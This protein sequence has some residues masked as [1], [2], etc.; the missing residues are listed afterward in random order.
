MLIATQSILV[1]INDFPS[2]SIV[3]SFLRGIVLLAHYKPNATHL[4]NPK[5]AL[6]GLKTQRE[7]NKDAGYAELLEIWNFEG[8]FHHVIL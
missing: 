8:I 5:L 6:P 3:R 2:M 1:T 7:K 4:A